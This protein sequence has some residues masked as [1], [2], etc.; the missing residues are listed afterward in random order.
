MPLRTPARKNASRS[1]G[2]FS[3]T[4]S[5]LAHSRRGPVVLEDRWEGL[6]PAQRP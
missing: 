2:V 5:T 6:A 3:R 1:L 4:P